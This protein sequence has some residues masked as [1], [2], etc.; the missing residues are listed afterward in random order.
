MDCPTCEA[1]V[2]AY[3]D[4]ELSARESAA[5]EQALT[6]CP[7]CRRRLQT[8]RTISGLLR[9]L[10][11][12]RASDLLRARIERELRVSVG[13]TAPSAPPWARLRM[14]WAAMAASLIVAVSAGWLGSALTSQGGRQSDEMIAG[15]LRVAMADAPVEVASSDRHT[16]KP[17]FAGR[18]DYAPPVHDLTAEGFPLVGGR[19]DVVAGRK[20]AVLVYRR[21]QH[22]VA[23]TLWPAGA[24]GNV[25]STVTQRDGFV[26]A[27]WRHA[28]FDMRAVS[29]LSP[30]DM[31]SFATAVDRAVDSDR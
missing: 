14:R 10:P 8:A 31:T 5:F 16:V 3:V 4:G 18:I 6:A 30:A 9:D 19:L 29:D 20:V 11:V 1:S 27:E 28:G 2:D 21:N 12:E 17:W 26:L 7:E 15:Y 22:R 13:D 23:L 25:A 24:A